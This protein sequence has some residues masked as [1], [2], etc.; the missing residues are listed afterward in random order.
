MK[1]R[2]SIFLSLAVIALCFLIFP[3]NGSADGQ[4]TPSGTDEY[5]DFT[6]C[7][8][9]QKNAHW[10]IE[11]PDTFDYHLD[12]HGSGQCASGNVCCDTAPRTTEC[13][14]AFNQ[15]ITTTYGKWSL[16]VQSKKASTS[17][18]SCSG[19]CLSAITV[20]CEWNGS[21]TFAISH[22][23]DFTPPP[24]SPIVID[25]NGSGVSL[26]SVANGVLFDL[27][28]TGIKGR[29]AWTAAGS[30]NAWLVL[31]RNHNGV[32]DNGAELFGNFTPQPTP[33][34]GEERNGFLA[35]A[36][37]DRSTYGGNDNDK[38]DP[39]DVIFSSLLLWQDV[40]HNGI[41]EPSELHTLPERGLATLDLKY[42]ESKRTDEYG[43]QF[44]YRAKVTDA[45]GATVGRW[46]WDVFLVSS[47]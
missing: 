36:E 9:L 13:W 37:Y 17:L 25:V 16:F 47:P 30:S 2:L 3:R 45:H 11:W 5:E 33:P 19:G 35:L 39:G 43:N 31:D 34:A 46:A 7:D 20:R 15:P 27:S 1:R 29:F 6:G 8:N 32:V 38:L 18:T 41:S 24:G 44:R 42:K 12:I 22:L 10:H 21:F 4:C 40:N 23:C 26:T 14:P 28:G